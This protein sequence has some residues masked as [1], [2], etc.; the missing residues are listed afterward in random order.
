MR[1]C[2]IGL[3]YVGLVTGTCLAE[4]GNDVWGID[5]D[6]KR[7]EMLQG[8]KLPIYEPGLDAYIKR[9]LEQGRLHFS[10]DIEEGVSESLF[11]MLAVGTPGSPDGSADTSQVI[12]AARAIG[13]TMNGYKIIVTKST[14][15]VGTTARVK[16]AVAEELSKRKRDDIE[17][18]VAFC[19]EFLKEG[20]AV[21]D[22]LHPDRIVIGTEN[23]RTSEFLKELFAPFVMRDNRFYTMSIP[24]AELTKYAANSM[25]ATRISFMNQLAGL[26]EKVG[27]DIEEIRM[28][29]GTDKRIGNA[30]L[31]A[32]LGYG[33]SC[34]PKDVKALLHSAEESGADLPILREV[35]RVNERQKRILLERIAGHFGEDLCDRTFA[36]WGLSF[37]PHTDDMRDAPSIPIINAL[38]E[39]GASVRA[40]D[41]AAMN[42]A[43]KIFGDVGI[44]YCKDAYDA[45]T[46][47]DGL[48]LLTEWPPFRRPDFE[49]VRSLMKTPV[50]FD[51]RN[52]YDPR[53]K[54]DL[55][56]VYFGIGRKQE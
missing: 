43:R 53:R 3:G 24:S 20:S 31:Y 36:V 54:K 45:V 52:Q 42:N 9:N 27:A 11:I 49:R 17:F 37:K 7:I 1:V 51:G 12:S 8:G 19:P 35:E 22:F 32:G 10:T 28:G 44:I 5:R 46:D 48:L 25:L 55:G 29:I 21:E 41:P 30:F 6:Q 56:F 2:M 4:N 23:D 14:V 13:R 33:G 18:D 15:P 38:R 34:L 39:R 50:I 47:S 26:C 40:Y 16:E